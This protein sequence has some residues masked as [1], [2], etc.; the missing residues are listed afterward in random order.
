MKQFKDLGIKPDIKSF[1][2]DKI[3]IKKILNRQITVHDHRIENSKYAE[4]NRNGKCLHLQIELGGTKHVVFT[5][6]SVLM[7]LIERVP[8]SDFPF[9]TTIVEENEHY[10]F[11]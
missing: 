3:K 1:T 7:E 10:E 4:S 5:G 8:K 2:G 11:T 9:T 6:S